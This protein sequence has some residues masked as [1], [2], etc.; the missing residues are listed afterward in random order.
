MLEY[1][2]GVR[3]CP[4]CGKSN[5]DDARFC[6]HCGTGLADRCPNC[7]AELPGEVAYCPSCGTEL[8]PESSE[9]RRFLTV[10]FADLVGFTAHSDEADPEDVRARLIPYH[11]RL[12]REIERF[13]GSVE[14]LIGDGVMAVFG[15]PTAH[16]DDP[17]RAVRAGLRIQDAVEELNEQHADLDLTVRIGINTGEAVVSHGGRGERI[18]GDVVNTASRLESV[19]PPG[20]VIVGESTHRA[21][22]LVIDYDTMDPIEVK[23]KAKPLAVWR[24]V[25]PRGRYGTDTALGAVTPFLGREPE[26]GVLKETFRRVVQDGSHQLV[27]IAAEPGVGKSRLVNEFWRWVDDR[28]ELVWWRQGRCLSYGEGITFWALGEVIKSHAG[29]RDSDT[30]EV[31][32]EKLE[33]ALE[34]LDLDASDREW[35]AAQLGPLVGTEGDARAM[36]RAEAFTAWRRFLEEMAAVRPLV[37]VIEDLHWADAALVEFLEELLVWSG[38]SSIL[39]ICTTRPELYQAHPAWGGGRRNSATLSLSPLT[40]DH[41]SRLLAALLD[42]AV[43][44][45]ATQRAL[46]DRAGGNPLYAEEF[47]RM[48]NDRGMLGR[49]G[50]LDP[51]RHREI[52]VPETVQALIGSRLDVLTEGEARVIE[53]ASVVGKV[54]WAGALEA[55][56]E[57][58]DVPEA[59]RSLV[60]RE[61]VRPVRNSSVEGEQEYAFWHALT[62]EVAY[63]R[64][65]RAARSRKHRALAEWITSVAGERTADHAELLAYHY[66]AALSLAEAAGDADTAALRE[67]TIVA[68]T[69]AGDR[70]LRLDSARGYD[71][72]R[73]ALD[74]MGEDDA[75]RPELLI[76]VG[77]AMDD[78]G[79]GSPLEAFE[80]AARL[81]EA[82]GDAAVAGQA[83][84]H[85]HDSRWLL[86]GI[87]AGAEDLDRAIELL[88][89]GPVSGRLANAYISRSGD[90]MFRGDADRQLTWAEKGVAIAESLELPDILSRGLSLRGVAR[91]H[92]GDTAAG[93]SDLEESLRLAEERAATARRLQSAHVNLADH[94]WITTGPGPA[95]EIYRRGID[96]VSARGGDTSWAEAET[97]WINFDLGRWDEVV[98]VADD[99]LE[100]WGTEQSSLYKP[101]AQS[102]KAAVHAWRGELTKASAL[103]ADYLPAAREIEDLQLLAPA[104]IF[105]ARTSAAAG[106][107]GEGAQ[108]AAEFITV[109][110]GKSPVYRGLHIAEA[111]RLLVA[112]GW[113]AEADAVL[114]GADTSNLRSRIGVDT[115]RAILAE[116]RA[117]TEAAGEGFAR[118]A[119]DWGEYG[120]VLE[121]ALAHYGAGRCLAGMGRRSDAINA[122]SAA[123]RLLDGLGAA[124][125]ISEIEAEAGDEAAVQEEA[126]GG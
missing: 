119:Q 86:S 61:W 11:R 87:G 57:G 73:R 79:I 121:Q 115:A 82:R 100:R 107:L 8:A 28:P 18:V 83:L 48:L 88:E 42:R 96:L 108:L 43:L 94:T 64:I 97:M 60:M 2:F 62:Q 37:M 23:G 125:T 113:Q 93:M 76:K 85:V 24:A 26:M 13:G 22:S 89:A 5:S 45:A 117:D 14:K 56:G 71:Y 54:F 20:G 126:G 17:E 31:T 75:G 105:A 16:E 124:P 50:H 38:D 44:P 19:A 9:E 65:P 59:L 68:M 90:Y 102:Y 53:N 10:L 120:H 7:G 104:L 25:E 29:I 34:S 112:A 33:A 30:A 118:A 70:A 12:G 63:G 114:E 36:D 84:M 122:F 3:S 55:L 72:Y 49:R 91:I 78:A 95:R 77:I 41:I 21:T 109:T 27:T 46:L 101:W 123:K 98:A 67:D 106:N 35:L 15:V 66:A 110:E 4:S 99:L 74:L 81:A 52:P 92:L 80:E 6:A 103:Q 111:T 1:S 69:M 47:V 39:V 32:A 58:D 51:G 40:D 116:A